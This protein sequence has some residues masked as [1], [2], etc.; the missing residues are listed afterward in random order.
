M[1]RTAFAACILLS[2]FLL[3]QV[4]PLIAKLILPWFGGSAAVWTACMLF[5]QTMLLAGYGYAHWLSRRRAVVERRVHAA[6]LALS[7]LALPIVPAAGWQPRGGEDP[8]TRILALLAATVGLPFLMLASTSPLL[9]AWSARRTGGA[10]PYRFYA[11]S[12]A[13]SMAGLL[14]YPVLVEP[15]LSG[16]QQAWMWSAG[17]AHLFAKCCARGWRGGRGAG[18]RG[19]R[20]RRDGGRR[21]AAV[22]GA[23]A[24]AAAGGVPFRLAAGGDGT[25]HGTDRGHSVS[26]GAPAG[27]VSVQLHFGL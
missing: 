15:Y 19:G 7:L 6:L 27:P 4:Q 1:A 16:H 3:F 8:L 26:V 18:K 5:F 11:V 23:A 12:N 25:H 2:A 9:Q 17:Y 22:G 21:G 24:V 20:G 14:T 10:A 13:G